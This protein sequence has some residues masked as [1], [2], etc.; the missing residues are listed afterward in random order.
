[1]IAHHA[2]DKKETENSAV[3]AKDH[4]ATHAEKDSF[5]EEEFCEREGPTI[6]DHPEAE[7]RIHFIAKGHPLDG[8]GGV[9]AGQIKAQQRKSSQAK[10]AYPGVIR[11]H[12]IPRSIYRRISVKH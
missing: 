9:R 3:S 4:P 11:W 6:P 10:Q 5:E 1:M 8:K 7:Q 2:L 12:K